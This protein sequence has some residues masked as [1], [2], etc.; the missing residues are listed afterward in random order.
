M[1]MLQMAA[2]AEATKLAMNYPRLIRFLIT[3]EKS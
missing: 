1:K 3:G 2:F